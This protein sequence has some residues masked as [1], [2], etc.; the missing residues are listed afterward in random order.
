[1]PSQD[2]LNKHTSQV[3]TDMPD[4]LDQQDI[5]DALDTLNGLD[6]FRD[7][8]RTISASPTVTLEASQEPES[9]FDEFF[10]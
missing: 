3:A 5:E 8:E 6:R 9:I 4:G 2:E 10:Q 7:L 1:V